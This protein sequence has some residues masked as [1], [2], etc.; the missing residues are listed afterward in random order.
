[1]NGI[2]FAALLARAST[3]AV[4]LKEVLVIALSGGIMAKI[5]CRELKSIGILVEASNDFAPKAA[6]VR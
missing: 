3:D 5:A 2:E 4:A 6:V 1:M